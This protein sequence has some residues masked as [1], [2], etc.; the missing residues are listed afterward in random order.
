MKKRTIDWLKK[1]GTQLLGLIGILSFINL[2]YWVSF[3]VDP[4]AGSQSMSFGTRIKLF[5]FSE[6]GPFAYYFLERG[7]FLF[8]AVGYTVAML[9]V[10][11]FSAIKKNNQPFRL[12]AHAAVVIWFFIGFIAV[13][14]RSV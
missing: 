1:T 4:V 11:L 14:N 8:Y 13:V 9:G 12:A 3:N 6:S 7:K 5:Y 10:F 2:C